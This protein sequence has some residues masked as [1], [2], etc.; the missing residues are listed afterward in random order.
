MT[1]VINNINNNNNNNN[2]HYHCHR[3]QQQRSQ[4][5]APLWLLLT[6]KSLSE[7]NCMNPLIHG[8]EVEDISRLNNFKE[9]F[10]SYKRPPLRRWKKDGRKSDLRLKLTKVCRCNS[11]IGIHS[12]PCRRTSR[13][14]HLQ[15]A[16]AFCATVWPIKSKVTRPGHTTFKL[17]FTQRPSVSN[18]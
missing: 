2:A 3:H 18:N 17:A 6:T 12:E 4:T 14:W 11:C 1:I 10:R 15:T 8:Y 13:E 5:S 16:T 7:K 9:Y